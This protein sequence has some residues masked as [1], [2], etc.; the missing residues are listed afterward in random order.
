MKEFFILEGMYIIFALIILAITAYVTTRD[1][2]SKNAFKKGMSAVFIFLTFAIFA[3][4]FVTKSRINAV[5]DAFNKNKPILCENRIYTKGAN[6]IEILKSRDWELK[7]NNFY[8][9]H[10]T[11]TFFVARCIVK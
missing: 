8:S 11:R 9:P 2:M 7:N 4:Y 3:H 6:Y 10:Y 1:F 5:I